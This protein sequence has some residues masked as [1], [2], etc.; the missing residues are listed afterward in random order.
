MGRPAQQEKTESTTRKS[1]KPS[2]ENAERDIYN[3]I[4]QTNR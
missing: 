4:K 3:P 1:R 2:E